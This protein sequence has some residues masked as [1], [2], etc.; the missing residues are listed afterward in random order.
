[1]LVQFQLNT[2]VQGKI[3]VTINLDFSLK[4]FSEHFHFILSFMNNT[5]D[6]ENITKRVVK[7]IR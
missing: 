1:M 5:V 2:L 3:C 4:A 7:C 6:Y